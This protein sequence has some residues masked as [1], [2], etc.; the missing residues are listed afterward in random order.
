MFEN[1]EN[2]KINLERLKDLGINFY[3]DDFGTGY[4]NFERIMTCP[5]QTIKF[6]KGLLYRAFTSPSVDK[7][8]ATL[9]PLF[10]ENGFHVLVEG[11]EDCEQKNFAISRGFEY[12]QGYYFSK[13][14]PIEKL[15]EYF[16]GL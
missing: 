3:L 4:S 10:K 16:S 5:L 12:I 11:V 2:V 1:Y 15:D 6:D 8:I 13:P 7:M 14:I 9:I